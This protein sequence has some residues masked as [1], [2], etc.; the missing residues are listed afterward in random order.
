MQISWLGLSSFEIT[1]KTTNGEVVLVT[2]PYDNQTGLRFP[3]TIEGNV[4]MITHDEMDANNIEAVTGSPYI[5][6]TPGEF[7]VRGVFVFG[8]PAPLKREQKKGISIENILYRIESEGIHLA[9][10]GAIDRELTDEELKRLQN[11]DILMV[12]V[13][14]GGVLS[15]SDAAEVIRQIEPRVIIPMT[16]SIPNLKAKYESVDAFCKAMGTCR[17]EHMNKFKITRKDLP[18]EDMLIVTLER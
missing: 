15:P 7:E 8:I 4:V 1:T 10:L 12:P 2:D 18:E 6:R 11:I 16:H 14:G 17:R 9:H 3:R 5:I 13:G